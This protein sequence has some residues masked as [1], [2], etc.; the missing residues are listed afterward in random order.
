MRTIDAEVVVAV[1]GERNTHGVRTYGYGSLT[2][3]RHRCSDPGAGT[4]GCCLISLLFLVYGDRKIWAAVRC[5]GANV[6]GV[7]GLLQPDANMVRW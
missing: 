5:A 7:S 6:V 1:R 2:P 3:R 4:G